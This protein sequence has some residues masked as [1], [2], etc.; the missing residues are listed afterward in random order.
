MKRPIVT[1]AAALLSIIPSLVLAAALAAA[2]P[3]AAPDGTGPL[4]RTAAARRCT[5]TPATVATRGAPAR[6]GYVIAAR[7]GWSIG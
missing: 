7:M 2:P 4:A 1:L 3:A 6:T 5:P